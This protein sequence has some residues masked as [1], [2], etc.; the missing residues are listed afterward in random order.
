[1]A[2]QWRVHLKWLAVTGAEA[3]TPAHRLF[4]TR[5]PPVADI[6]R[7]GRPKIF[8]PD[9][10]VLTEH[11]PPGSYGSTSYTSANPTPVELSIPDTTTL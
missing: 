8:N 4:A 9:W 10:D 3:A 6:L 5:G 2:D 7:D 11:Y 1:M